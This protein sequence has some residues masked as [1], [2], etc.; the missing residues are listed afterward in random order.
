V[1]V[2]E[3]LGAIATL[4]TVSREQGRAVTPGVAVGA[5]YAAATESLG[6]AGVASNAATVPA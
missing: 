3:V 4:E 6:A 5:A 2:E 1:T